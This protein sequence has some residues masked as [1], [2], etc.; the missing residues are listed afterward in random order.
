M[1]FETKRRELIDT[2][3][4]RGYLNKKSVIKAMLNVPREVFLPE[5]KKKSAYVDSPLTIG[6]GQTISAPHMNAMMCEA[7]DLKEGQKLLEIGTGSGYHA[8]LCAYLIA[9]EGSNNQGHVYTVERIESLANSAKQNIELAGFKDNIDVIYSDGTMGY[10]VESP[11]DRV[12]VTAAS[13]LPIPQPLKNQLKDGGLM[14]I[15]A[16]SKNS[17][18]NLYLFTKKGKEFKRKSLGAVRFVPLIGRYSFEE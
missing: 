11:Y 7:L 12:L 3:I 6:Q 8:A 9:P 15:P 1:D 18:Q 17:T 5:D 2:L 16:G 10:E 14:C 13:K 4:K